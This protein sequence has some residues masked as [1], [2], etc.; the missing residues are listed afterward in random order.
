MKSYEQILRVAEQVNDLVLS[1]W[2]LFMQEVPF[3][4]FK[5]CINLKL[6]NLNNLKSH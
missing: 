4:F 2:I 5:T 1:H 6:I 3:N